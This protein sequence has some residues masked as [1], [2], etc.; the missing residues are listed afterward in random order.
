M[1]EYIQ[2]VNRIAVIVGLLLFTL[3]SNVGVQCFINSNEKMCYVFCLLPIQYVCSVEGV[4]NKLK[5]Y[6][7]END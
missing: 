7:V 3:P 5:C 1:D 2:N 4:L 6:K